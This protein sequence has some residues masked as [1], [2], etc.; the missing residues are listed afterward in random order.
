M[1]GEKGNILKVVENLRRF[2]IRKVLR[3]KVH[4]IMI[5]CELVSRE[6]QNLEHKK[7]KLL[8]SKK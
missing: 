8:Q 4:Q 7:T 2:E 6:E 5:Y 3:M 1:Q